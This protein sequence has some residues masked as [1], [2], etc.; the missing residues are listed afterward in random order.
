M[1]A[2]PLGVERAPERNGFGSLGCGSAG[3]RMGRQWKGDLKLYVLEY[4]TA[5]KG[6][7]IKREYSSLTEAMAAARDESLYRATVWEMDGEH[8]HLV[9]RRFKGA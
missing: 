8:R 9:M 7:E 1:L 4:K 5:F 2:V 6:P 3:G